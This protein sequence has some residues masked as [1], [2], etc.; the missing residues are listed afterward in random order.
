MVDVKIWGGK[1]ICR[2]VVLELGI[3]VIVFGKSLKF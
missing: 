2:L 3:W 1:D